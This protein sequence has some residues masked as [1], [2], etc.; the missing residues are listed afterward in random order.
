MRFLYVASLLL[1]AFSLFLYIGV[2]SAYATSMETATVP[3]EEVVLSDPDDLTE[4]SSSNSDGGSDSASYSVSAAAVIDSGLE[5]L[6]SWEVA[7]SQLGNITLY[8]AADTN[9]A[10]IRIYENTFV[11]YN[12]STVYFYC[13]EYPDYQ[14]SASRFSPVYYRSDGSYN[15]TLLTINSIQVSSIDLVDYQ[16]YIICGMLLIIML[17]VFWRCI[18]K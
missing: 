1:F 5:G 11:N 14:F 13:P 6:A 16:D 2:P 15:S 7:S 18:F 12:N 8:A 4:Q 3:T 10:A 9:S 17:L